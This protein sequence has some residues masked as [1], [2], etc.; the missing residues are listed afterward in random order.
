MN[1]SAS[2]LSAGR[3]RGAPTIKPLAI[4]LALLM[5]PP[6]LPVL[7]HF[8]LAPKANAQ[9]TVCGRQAS[10]FQA[11]ATASNAFEPEALSDYEKQ[12]N[13]K[14]GDGNLI[15]TYGRTDLRM[16]FRAFMFDKLLGAINN[17]P[18]NRTAAEQSMIY[19]FQGVVQQHEIAQYTAATADRDLF[20]QHLCQWVPDTDL[21]KAYNET[22]DISPYCGY[23]VTPETALFNGPPDIPT[24]DYFT[25][26][27]YKTGYQLPLEAAAN[28][29]Q[30][31]KNL[32]PGGVAASL[33]LSQLQIAEM[34]ALS[35]VATVG[36]GVMISSRSIPALTKAILPFRIAQQAVRGGRVGAQQVLSLAKVAGAAI[37]TL[38]AVSAA[39][40]IV[41]TAVSVVFAILDAVAQQNEIDTLNADLNNAKNTPP[42][43]KAFLKDTSGPGYEKLVSVFLELTLPEYESATPLPLSGATDPQFV[44]NSSSVINQVG[45]IRYQDQDNEIWTAWPYSQNWFLITGFDQNGSPI[46]RFSN[47]L[48]YIGP[49]SSNTITAYKA[50]INNG[51]FMVAKLLPGKNDQICEAGSNGLYQ[52]STTNCASYTPDHLA[53]RDINGNPMNITMSQGVAYDSPNPANA[54]FTAG[55]G[56][57][58]TIQ[59][60]GIPAPTLLVNDVLPQG[61]FLNNY[62]RTTHPGI[63]TIQ[64]NCDSTAQPTSSTFNLIISNTASSITVPFRLA[65]DTT[66]HITSPTSFTLTY[67]TPVNFVVTATGTPVN[68]SIPPGPFPAGITITDHGNG[69]ASITG[70]PVESGNILGCFVI[71]T[72][73]CNIT[74][75]NQVSSD[76]SPLVVTVL[77]PPFANVTSPSQVTF[78]AGQYNEFVITLDSNAVTAAGVNV[79]Q[80]VDSCPSS[81]PSW[82]TKTS[83][84]NGD[85]FLSGTPP[86]LLNN[87]TFNL[88]FSVYPVGSQSFFSNCTFFSNPLTL[89]VGS[90]PSFPSSQYL[91]ALPGSAVPSNYFQMGSSFNSLS[92]TG[93]LPA[94]VSFQPVSDAFSFGGSVP[95]NTATGD[96]P[97][98]INST[99]ISNNNTGSELFHFVVGQPPVDDGFKVFNL[100]LN[101]PANLLINPRGFPKNAVGPLPAMTSNFRNVLS[102]LGL[103]LPAGLQQQPGPMDG[104]IQ[105]TGTPTQLAILAVAFNGT[106][107][108]SNGVAPDL[109]EQ[110]QIRVIKPGDINADGVV[111][112]R[113][114]AEVQAAINKKLGF[115]GYDNLADVN[116]DGIVNSQDLLLV[117]KNLPAGLR[118]P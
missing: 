113:D 108:A 27:G 106:F 95:A 3:F 23:T 117:A 112:C 42:D 85:M 16:S 66:V 61:C 32:F 63:S 36:A 97:L 88:A 38:G 20:M 79:Y 9:I 24:I 114:V 46:S 2:F 69:I 12:Y 15:Y 53:M 115:P 91:I 87:Q 49:D 92:Y 70:T 60:H 31:S 41:T 71:G 40:E 77:S 102:V 75:F 78:H 100:V 5:L 73:A 62:D 107:T 14:P 83:R 72:T 13:L 110:I 111:D 18:A 47:Y 44:T 10:I 86:F 45:A 35:S 104:S 7:G 81:E 19:Y 17:A 39:F 64:L 94:G 33:T 67:G 26:K 6:E 82:L 74:A 65:V 89:N 28:G 59:A 68:F 118:C 103:G 93:P 1:K 116:N 52:G 98:S 30:A 105:V 90:F 76:T 34:A 4:L 29:T 57:S 55:V 54:A 8:S 56:G 43:L 37:R 50:W 48:T 84:P 22:V 109:S 58:V 21:E 80:V 101:Q 96:Y 99:I 25:A 51:N 11:C